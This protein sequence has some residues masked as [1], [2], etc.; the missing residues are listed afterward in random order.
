M[1]D[2]EIAARLNLKASY[3]PNLRK[4][5]LDRLRKDEKLRDCLDL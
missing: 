1:K 5:G 2:K 4:G 3:I